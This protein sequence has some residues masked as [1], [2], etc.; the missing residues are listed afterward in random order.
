MDLS[1]DK[2]GVTT[3]AAYR[4]MQAGHPSIVHSRG[5]PLSRDTETSATQSPSPTSRRCLLPTVLPTLRLAVGARELSRRRVLMCPDSL[6]KKSQRISS[7]FY[8]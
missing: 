6:H 4:G 2:T 8:I 5:T 7:K 1:K 3:L